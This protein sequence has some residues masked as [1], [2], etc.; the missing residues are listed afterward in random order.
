MTR[1]MIVLG[2]P[3]A[4]DRGRFRVL[5]GFGGTA[6]FD[7]DFRNFVFVPHTHDTLMLGLILEGRKRF[8]R[9]GALHDLGAGALSVVNPGE[10]HTGGVVGMDQHLRYTGVYPGAA[11][12]AEAGFP[13]GADLRD[14]VIDDAALRPFFL[15][16]LSPGTPANEA[17]EALLIALTGLA[18]RHGKSPP[19]ALPACSSAVMRA[20]D[21]IR[22]DVSAELRLESIAD[23]AQI[24]PRHLIR[25]FRR[26]LCMTPQD[27]V[28]QARVHEAAA[29]LRRG[30]AASDVAQAA[31]FAD[32]PHMTRAFRKV[33]GI[34]PAA[35]ARSWRR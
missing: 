5:P 22:A 26:M 17:E 23:Q 25:S 11:L 1:D 16:A 12:L 10:T 33:M 3:A 34:T 29:R 31:G 15:R 27:Y 19:R 20:V 30:E 35:Y 6:M 24:S 13:P 18:A 2:D 32:Q 7:A 14:S 8:M 9:T 21:Y 28:R 4:G